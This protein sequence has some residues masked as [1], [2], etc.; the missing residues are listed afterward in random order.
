MDYATAFSFPYR[1]KI[2]KFVPSP[3]HNRIAKDICTDIER[4]VGDDAHVLIVGCGEGGEGLEGFS[5]EFMNNNVL[6]PDIWETNF[7][8]FLGDIHTLPVADGSFDAIVCQAV[9]EHIEQVELA[10]QEIHRV[11]VQGGY[12]YLDVPFLQGYHSLPTDYWRFTEY[13]LEKKIGEIGGITTI[14]S[15][16]SKGPTSTIVWMLCEY[17][18]Y[19]LTFGHDKGRK[20]VSVGLRLPIF[21]LKYLDILLER[22]HGFDGLAM[23][24]PSAV[25]YYGQKENDN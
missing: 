6:G 22:T 13:G 5:E 16:T 12:I 18:A 8:T 3:T 24:I 11:T 15:G 23:T 10:L 19:I 7:T 9:L 2:K 20:I 14:S 25:Y 17:I 1:N 21:W 4:R